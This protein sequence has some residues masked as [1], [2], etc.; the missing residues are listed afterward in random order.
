MRAV[1]PLVRRFRASQRAAAAAEMDL[2]RRACPGL[3]EKAS[4]AAAARRLHMLGEQAPL[5]PRCAPAP[6]P[7]PPPPASLPP[8]PRAL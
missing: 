8:Q 7:P 4:V 2:L 6:P 1:P 3:V 5:R